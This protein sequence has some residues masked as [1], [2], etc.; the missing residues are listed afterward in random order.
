ML[1]PTFY[2][3]PEVEVRWI[4]QQLQRAMASHLNF[5]DMGSLGL[6]FLPAIHRI[7]A[8]LGL[9][10]PLWRYTRHIRRGLRMA[11]MKV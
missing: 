3:S 4:E 8:K 5:I 2:L 7:G 9:K 11:G 6:P 1:A 10:P